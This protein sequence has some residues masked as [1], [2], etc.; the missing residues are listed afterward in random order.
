[1]R[2]L[3]YLEAELNTSPVGR[4]VLDVIYSHMDE[5]SSLINGNRAVMVAWQRYH[6]PSFLV[7]ATDGSFDDHTPVRKEIDGV[8]LQQLLLRM[9]DAFQQ[10]GSRALAATVARYA[11][12]VMTA[13]RECVS[14]ADLFGR[15]RTARHAGTAS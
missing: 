2:K 6:G 8:S 11:A 5:V 4:E 1:M 14:L 7:A 10:N 3:E 15:I 13:A 9:G 12:P